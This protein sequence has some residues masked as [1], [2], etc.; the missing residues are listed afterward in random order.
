MVVAPSLTRPRRRLPSE[1]KLDAHIMDEPDLAGPLFFCL[2]FGTFLL[3]TGKVGDTPTGT[4][5]W[6]YHPSHRRITS[7]P[8]WGRSS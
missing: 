6:R 1:Q 2:A 3:L 7:P 8:Q 4:H 5:A